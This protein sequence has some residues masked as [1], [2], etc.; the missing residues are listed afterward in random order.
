M[1]KIILT[2]IISLLFSILLKG[3]TNNSAGFSLSFGHKSNYSFG[4]IAGQLRLLKHIDLDLGGSYSFFNGYGY[5]SGI[6]FAPLNTKVRPLLGFS[7]GKSLG[8][9]N[10]D[11]TEG[12]TN[13]SYYEISPIEFIYTKLGVIFKLEQMEGQERANQN[14]FFVLALTYR[15]AITDYSIELVNG[16]TY[17]NEDYLHSKMEDGIGFSL[18][19]IIL[20]GKG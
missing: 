10:Y 12:E 15:K 1:K 11:I 3:Q 20:F 19:F 8:V 4:G 17:E 14:G 16:P 13:T 5:S 18:S 9:K 2:F 7:Y 6:S